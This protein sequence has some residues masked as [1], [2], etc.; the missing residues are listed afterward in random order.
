MVDKKMAKELH[1]GSFRRSL[2]S[3]EM[4]IQ[5]DLIYFD[6]KSPFLSA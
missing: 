5:I 1:D 3:S 2:A 4:K 6:L